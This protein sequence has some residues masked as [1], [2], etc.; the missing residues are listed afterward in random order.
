MCQIFFISLGLSGQ[1]RWQLSWRR[2][3]AFPFSF[4][5]LWSL[6]FQIA[7]LHVR[8][9]VARSEKPAERLKIETFVHYH[10]FTF[11]FLQ[12]CHLAISFFERNGRWLFEDDMRNFGHEKN[13]QHVFIK[14]VI[15]R[16]SFLSAMKRIIS[17]RAIGMCPCG[18]LTACLH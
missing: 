15:L 7:P 5:C 14:S 10:F 1:Q 2:H 6:C 8:W 4:F 12:A 18:Y 17:T 9:K 13:S 11:L 3:L 16:Q